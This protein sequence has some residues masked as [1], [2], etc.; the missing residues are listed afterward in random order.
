MTKAIR[1]RETGEVWRSAVQ[2]AQV[3]GV[4]PGAVVHH[5]KGRQP[6]VA[7][8]TLE[9]APDVY[10][11]PVARSPVVLVRDDQGRLYAGYTTL[12]RMKGVTPAKARAIAL[13][14]GGV[15]RERGSVTNDLFGDID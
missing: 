8:V 4:T 2:T 1:C 15:Y 6:T 10:F 3:L 5:L 13:K 12:A 7:G 11:K 9:Y 14:N